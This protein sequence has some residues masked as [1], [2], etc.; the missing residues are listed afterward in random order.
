MQQH[1]ATLHSRPRVACPGTRRLKTWCSQAATVRPGAA[2]GSAS[3][4][5]ALARA[6][7]PGRVQVRPSPRP[8]P[9]A[10]QAADTGMGPKQ[11]HPAL[12]CPLR[13]CCLL[14]CAKQ[15]PRQ[16]PAPKAEGSR[17]PLASS[18]SLQRTTQSAHEPRPAAARS[19]PRPRTAPS[20]LPVRPPAEQQ[21]PPAASIRRVAQLCWCLVC[22]SGLR[23]ALVGPGAGVTSNTT[24]LPAHAH[25]HGAMD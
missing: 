13:R 19:V 10:C 6:P 22:C 23:R 18:R 24:P 14:C 8:T 11:N 25:A 20:C 16:P 5:L 17:S 12:Y 1:L 21:G 4:M 7:T 15:P 9:T 3:F 2:Q